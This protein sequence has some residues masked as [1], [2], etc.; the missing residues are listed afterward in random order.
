M[1]PHNS[2]IYQMIN[3]N[4]DILNLPQFMSRNTLFSVKE[5]SEI[6]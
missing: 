6:L 1:D 3:Q 5:F 4:E 2:I